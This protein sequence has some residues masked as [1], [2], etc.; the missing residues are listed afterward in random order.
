MTRALASLLTPVL[1]TVKRVADIGYDSKR[2]RLL[3][4]RFLEDAVE[5]YELN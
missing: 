2:N 1:T 5:V 4:P 3:V